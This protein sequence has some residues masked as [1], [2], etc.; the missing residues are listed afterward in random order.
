V[1]KRICLR[2][3]FNSFSIFSISRS[4]WKFILIVINFSCKK[5][6]IGWQWFSCIL[7][8]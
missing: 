8:I 3:N 6:Y 5:V 1:A 7:N 2:N 4:S